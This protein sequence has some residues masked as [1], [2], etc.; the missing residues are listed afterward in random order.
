M[1]AIGDKVVCINDTGY[2]PAIEF[3]PSLPKK[4]KVYTISAT[5]WS[6]NWHT[7][8]PNLSLQLEEIPE[9]HPTGTK[10]FSAHRFRP[11]HPEATQHEHQNEHELISI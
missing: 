2:G 5:S 4:G 6:R 1:F 9:L 8:Q 3:F 7:G 10:G 11:L